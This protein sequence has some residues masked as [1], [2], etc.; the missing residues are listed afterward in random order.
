MTPATAVNMADML[1]KVYLKD[2]VHSTAACV[3]LMMLCSRY[4]LDEGMWD[5]IVKFET[6]CLSSLMSL[7]KNGDELQKQYQQVLQEREQ[8]KQAAAN[9]KPLALP[10]P[11]EFEHKHGKPTKRITDKEMA[12]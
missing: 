9:K 6:V 10:A 2:L 7:E 11:P 4:N 12:K 3:P 5:F 8:A 1:A